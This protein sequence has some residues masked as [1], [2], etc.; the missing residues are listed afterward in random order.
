MD[1]QATCKVTEFVSGSN[2][3]T[4]DYWSDSG[5]T[6]ISHGGVSNLWGTTWTVSDINASN[7]GAAISVANDSFKFLSVAY[8][9][10][11]KITVYYTESGGTPRS[12]AMMIG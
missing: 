4:F 2:L 3:A 10:H 9:D 6:I 12:Q 8:V 7:F 11:V 5:D 1:G